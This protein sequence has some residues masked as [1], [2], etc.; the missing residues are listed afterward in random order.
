[1]GLRQQAPGNPAFCGPAVMSS[2]SFFFCVLVNLDG[3]PGFSLDF[4]PATPLRSTALTHK[5]MDSVL[6]LKVTAILEY[7]MPSATASIAKIRLTVARSPQSCAS[8][9]IC[10]HSFRLWF[11]S[12]TLTFFP[13]GPPFKR[14]FNHLHT[15][16]GVK[17]P[18]K[19]DSTPKNIIWRSIYLQL[20]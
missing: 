2:S 20:F 17:C 9:R 12:L 5:R 15:F 3:L 1:M 10:W 19:N 14:S 7:G 8:S 4:K 13:L 11:V 6:T 18:A 16:F